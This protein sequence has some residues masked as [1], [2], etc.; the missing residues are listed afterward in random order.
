MMSILHCRQR[1]GIGVVAEFRNPSA[2]N[3]YLL[4]IQKLMIYSVA[5]FIMSSWGQS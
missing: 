2:G 3:C 1:S 5:K 4:K